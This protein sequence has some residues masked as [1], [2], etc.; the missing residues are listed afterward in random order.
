MAEIS[1]CHTVN[2][3]VNLCEKFTVITKTHPA[4][5]DDFTHY[6]YKF[7][8][9]LRRA[10]ISAALGKVSSYKSNHASWEF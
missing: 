3:M 4:V 10:A 8:C 6:L 2:E 5:K 1:L 9:Y 7:P